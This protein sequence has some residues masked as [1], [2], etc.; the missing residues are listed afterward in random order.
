LSKLKYQ[1]ISCDKK[2]GRKKNADEHAKNFYHR[3]EEIIIRKKLTFG[4]QI[5]ISG[6]KDEI[7]N[8]VQKGG[9]YSNILITLKL[10]KIAKISKK[11]ANKAIKECGLNNVGWVVE[12]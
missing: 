7:L 9:N 11:E 1:C 10:R 4:E 5:E 12:K 6:L 3:I 8:E 2:F